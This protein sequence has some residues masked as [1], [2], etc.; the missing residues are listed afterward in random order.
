MKFG[1]HFK[2]SVVGSYEPPLGD[3]PLKKVLDL[4]EP[5]PMTLKNLKSAMT[6]KLSIFIILYWFLG[7]ERAPN[8]SSWGEI[9]AIDIVSQ[10]KLN[11]I[12]KSLNFM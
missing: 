4:S 2:K 8:G 11:N 10:D 5:Y 12:E 9:M 3:Y 6:R 1:L 7:S